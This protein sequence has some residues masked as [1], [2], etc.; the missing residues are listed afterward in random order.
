MKQVSRFFIAII[1]ALFAFQAHSQVN[2]TLAFSINDVTFDTIGS[3]VRPVL[4]GCHYTDVVGV[5]NMPYLVKDYLLPHNAEITGI[6]ILDSN[7]FTLQGTYLVYP[8]QTPI[9]LDGRPAPPFVEPD[10]AYYNSSSRYVGDVAEIQTQSSSYGYGLVRV[11]VFP[12]QYIPSAQQ[13]VLFTSIR[14][15]I[16]YQI[17]GTDSMTGKMSTH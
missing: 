4:A 13:L 6:S 8:T 7:H 9:I 10:T 11:K 3:Y 17:A 5:P 1:V 16:E 14:L 15:S 2:D 12:L